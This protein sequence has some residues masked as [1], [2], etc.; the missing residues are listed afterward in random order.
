MNRTI[1]KT[2]MRA[3]MLLLAVLC[4]FT[5][6]KAQEV[7]IDGGGGTSSNEF[8]PCY[9]FDYYSLTQQIYTA[10]E[11]STSGT[12]SYIC[13]RN[14]GGQIT[15]DLSIYM[16]HTSKTVFTKGTDWVAMGSDNLV[17]AGAVTFTADGWTTIFLDQ[18]F[19]YNGS[20]NLLVGVVDNTGSAIWINGLDFL[21]FS[22]T[23]KQAIRSFS[24]DPYD[25]ENLDVTGSLLGVKNQITLGFGL[26]CP[27]PGLS[28]DGITSNSATLSWS[29]GSGTYNVQYRQA[30]GDWLKLLDA[31]QVCSYTLTGLS[32]STG[33]EVRVQ[34]I[35]GGATSDWY[36][37]SF[38]TTVVATEVGSG[39]SDGFEGTSCDWDLINGS[40]SN[41]WS[42]GKAVSNGGTRALY[43]SCDGGASNDYVNQANTIV[44]ATKLFHFSEGEY[45]FSYDW[46]AKGETSMQPKDFLRV[47]LVPGSQTLVAGGQ[48]S[49][50][51]T[52][53]SGWI[54]LDG[55]NVLNQVTDW[56][57]RTATVDV[58]GT[59]YLTFIWVNDVSGKNSPPAA[60]DNVSIS[61]QSCP[62]TVQGLTAVGNSETEATLSWNAGEASQWQVSYSTSNSFT[63]ERQVIVN[64]PSY[65]ITGLTVG[66]TYY[67]RVRSCCSSD[68]FGA[69]SSVVSFEPTA[70]HA[71]GSG[72]Q[73]SQVLPVHVGGY[74][75]MSQQIYSASEL[76][77]AGAILSIDFYNASTQI[78]RNI[79]IY[80]VYTTKSK[81]TSKTDWVSVTDNDLV[82]RGDVTFVKNAWTTIQLNK[83]FV[84]DGQS[85]IV[86]IVD[87]NQGTYNNE[88][89]FR[90]FGASSQ[91]LNITRSDNKLNFDPKAASG[92]SGTINNSK[93][94]IRLLKREP[95]V[96][97]TNLTVSCTGTTAQISWK[98]NSGAPQWKLAYRPEGATNFTEVTA[99]TNPYTLSGLDL[100][101]V[102]EV[103]VRSV[104]G[105]DISEWT[106]TT[107]FVTDL[108]D[109]E[110]M[111][112][113]NI[114]LTDAYGDGWS[115][116][117]LYVVDA[118]TNSTIGTFTLAS[119]SSGTF[120]LNACNGRTIN[121]VYEGK[122][123]QYENGYRITDANDNVI[124]EHTGCR[125]SSACTPPT[126]GVIA[127]YTVNCT[128]WA[129]PTGLA[130]SGSI[131]PAGAIFSEED[132]FSVKL[133]WTEN[134][135]PAAT[136]WVVGYKV[137][138][139]QDFTE[140]AAST[141][142]FT[143]TGLAANTTYYVKVRPSSDAASDKWSNVISF[144]TPLP[145][146]PPTNLEATNITHKEATLS[147]TENSDPKA[148]SW[149]VAYKAQGEANYTEVTAESN[150][151]TLTGL[152]GDTKY[153]VKV[154]P[155]NDDNVIK[156]SEEMQFTTISP[157]YA[158]TLKKPTS[159][160]HKSAKLSWT[161]NSDPQATSWVVAYKA[162][163]E[164]DFTEVKASTNPYTLTGLTAETKY[165]VKVRSDIDNNV[166][167]W[168]E[169]KE[170]T[171]ISP[172][173][174]PTKLTASD[175][176]HKEV[177]L[178]WK[179][180]SDPKATS[181]VVAYK[182]DGETGFT[183]VTASSNPFTLTGLKSE[184]KYTV[185]VRPAIDDNVIKWSAEIEFT[186][187]SP[188]YA[189]TQLAAES[190]S[191]NDAV[192]S[193]TENSDPAATQWWVYY[194]ADG[195]EEFLPTVAN[196]VPFT[197][198]NLTPDTKYTVKVCPFN[199]V[200]LSNWSD[201]LTIITSPILVPPT[202]PT[203]P[204]DVAVTDITTDAA[205]LT[206]TGNFESYDIQL[207]TPKQPNV[208]AFEQVGETK[209]ATGKLTQ[210]TFDLN[211][212][213]GKGWIAI[214]H[215][216]VT[217]QSQL[218]IDDIT[219]T[220]SK[221]GTVL[222]ENF[223]NELMPTRWHN[224]NNFGNPYVWTVFANSTDGQGNPYGRGNY[225]AESTS[226][227]DDDQLSDNWLI[228]V[229]D[230]ELGGTLTLYARSAG[231]QDESFGVYV[232][233]ATPVIPETTTTIE[234]ET[235]PYTLSELVSG[236]T[237]N[238]KV[239]GLSGITQ[240]DWSEAVTFTTETV[241]DSY[242]LG[243]VNGDG[244]V[245]PADAIMILYHYFGVEQ[246]GFIEAAA[247]VNGDQ[248]ISPADAIEALYLYFNL[249]T[250][251]GA[252]ATRAK[253]DVGCEPE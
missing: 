154:R 107:S 116:N 246:T 231:N 113:I 50:G 104:R 117:K 166:I 121:F 140:V 53:P 137:D 232:A 30:G 69:W 74:Y 103:K 146:F 216:D 87:D 57:H 79:D 145:I 25:V 98:E 118:L 214:R 44:F 204:A 129:A 211:E 194:K 226:S 184:T 2:R 12:I 13:F 41:K 248:G 77:S 242:L 122:S 40:Y 32:V 20:S 249:N 101:T 58:S 62:Y 112:V 183:E 198:A 173:Y 16:L 142:P 207:T 115:N 37:I 243:D 93:N 64:N 228:I 148:T 200:S 135:V 21:V 17:Y 52:L 199:D 206:W 192:L 185:K 18:P 10:K 215:C 139:A 88:T 172:I 90:T 19:D 66:T 224:F 56:T 203:P 55:G 130:Q 210:Y 31:T 229:P 165:T 244:S 236:R 186:T 157:I 164:A 138:G 7:T 123:Y 102:Y 251:S 83:S 51:S 240:S 71:I 230:M 78:T 141:N 144:T 86:L 177:K 92:Y 94:Q 161:E 125:S 196:S 208:S 61:R 225:Y 252:R 195:E 127:T 143:L 223:E 170:F 239:K 213:S 182:A 9:S 220:N 153:T 108:C 45:T 39:W 65:T 212:Y 28:A 38:S 72:N 100:G 159:V 3:A 5:G 36:T 1:I 96:K 168:S 128:T 54:A 221:G 114:T 156:W 136:S 131:V 217:N 11:I 201:E 59:Y 151:F 14:T 70:K 85:N 175:I 193:W 181:W 33:Y 237:Y 178:S 73:T 106:S 245:T 150:P 133:S 4:C 155:V 81:F 160:T 76:G 67:A 60:V 187:L 97:P 80:M 253:T 95:P 126:E 247:D 43:I 22:T 169:E 82:F 152:A 6:S 120:I 24:E 250:S 35:C 205:T 218:I 163:G 48:Y 34:S 171:T 176:T 42:W 29:G 111:C 84:Y 238:V 75:S 49:V 241:D 234:D 91:A 219:L 179:E 15:R 132:P 227:F 63:S 167:K 180:N 202:P 89:Y 99:T 110:N 134:S 233:M 105:D 189:P 197:L 27:R 188:I 147:W 109:E 68:D 119:G 158:P 23:S 149:V 46:R 222:T 174:A 209:T 190:I 8:L 235:S 191:T 26:S 47:A 124:C 162:D